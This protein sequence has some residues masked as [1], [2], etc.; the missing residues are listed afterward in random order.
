MEEKVVVNAYN[1][2]F[3]SK[4]FMSST[5]N[6]IKQEIIVIHSRFKTKNCTKR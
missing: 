2:H 3:I 6:N 5:K 1:L 4:G